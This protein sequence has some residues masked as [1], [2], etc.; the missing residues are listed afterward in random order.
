MLKKAKAWH[1]GLT[2]AGKVILWSVTAV[3]GGAVISAAAAPANTDQLEVKPAVQEEAKTPTIEK[4]TITETT[5]V[6]FSKTTIED[7]NLERGKTNIRTAGVLGIK[8][9]TYE[10]TLQDGKEIEKKLIKE[11]LTTPPVSEVTAVGTHIAPPPRQNCDR[12]YT[13]CVPN[14]SYDLDCPDIGFSVEVIGSDPHGF[15]RDNDGY[16]CESY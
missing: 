4:K 10:L 9:F 13:P 8:T 3:L 6:T 12:N 1:S 16:G 14:V 15:D 7:A 5:E 2:R 11:E